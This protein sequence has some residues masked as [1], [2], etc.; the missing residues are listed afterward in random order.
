MKK[1]ILLALL[2]AAGLFTLW[3][4]TNH[5][6]R[7]TV[8]IRDAV[9]TVDLAVTEREKERGLSGR[10]SLAPERGMLFVYSHKE[11]YP[12]WMRGMRVPIDIIWI[13]DATIVDITKNVPVSDEPVEKL[14]LYHPAAAADKVLE[15]NAGLSDRYGFA[16][17]DSVRIKN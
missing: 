14:P 1:L 12:F 6:M 8:T 7:T 13:A 15:I 5:P 4:Y 9:F 16:V 11:R 17:G 3:Y 2:L 10:Q